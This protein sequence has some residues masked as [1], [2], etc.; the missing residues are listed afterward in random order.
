[1]IYI[2]RHPKPGQPLTTF[3]TTVTGFVRRYRAE[4]KEL[5]RLKGNT[6]PRAV[7]KIVRSI[8][9]NHARQLGKARFDE[10]CRE[11]NFSRQSP[12]VSWHKAIAENAQKLFRYASWLPDGDGELH[13]LAALDKEL[14]HDLVLS[15]ELHPS[16]TKSE[17]KRAVAARRSKQ[18]TPLSGISGQLRGEPP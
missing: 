13:L 17:L 18:R 7:L 5:G 9:F 2:P 10:L 6:K 11:L 8:T 15:R 16:S 14:L 1:M 4:T 12:R 3:P